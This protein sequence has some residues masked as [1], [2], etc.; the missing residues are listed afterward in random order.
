MPSVSSWVSVDFGLCETSSNFAKI[1]PFMLKFVNFFRIWLDLDEISVDLEE[2]KPNLDEILANLEEIK[3]NL[4]RLDKTDRPTTPIGG[5]Q[6]VSNVYLVGLMEISFLCSN[7]STDTL[8]SGFRGGDPLPTDIDIGL[9]C[10]WA[11]LAG[12]VGYLV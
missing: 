4:N 7:Q 9:A 6:Q 3:S 1:N 12:L 5:E 10:F 8:V 11:G 2:I